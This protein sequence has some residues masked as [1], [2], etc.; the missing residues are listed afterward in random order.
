M[1]QPL[2]QK[3]ARSSVFSQ[4]NKNVLDRTVLSDKNIQ[5]T[6]EMLDSDHSGGLDLKEVCFEQTP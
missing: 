3:D 1:D 5:N 4:K 2:V 6:F